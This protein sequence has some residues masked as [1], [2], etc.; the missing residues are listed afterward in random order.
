MTYDNEAEEERQ[1]KRL[2]MKKFEG[3]KEVDGVG[4]TLDDIDE[5]VYEMYKDDDKTYQEK[6]EFLQRRELAKQRLEQMNGEGQNV[7]A[8]PKNQYGDW[9]EDVNHEFGS[10]DQTYDIPDETRD[11][12]G[13]EKE[14]LSMHVQGD[15]S[16]SSSESGSKSNEGGTPDDDASFDDFLQEL[17]EEM[18]A[19]GESM[20]DINI[21]EARMVYDMFVKDANDNDG[22]NINETLESMEENGGLIEEDSLLHHGNGDSLTS[23]KIKSEVVEDKDSSTFDLVESDTQSLKYQFADEGN[24]NF[25]LDIFDASLPP[26]LPKSRVKRIR[27]AFSD[28]LAEPSLTTLIPIVRENL[29]EYLP[30]YWLKRKNVRDARFAIMKA[31]EEGMINVHVLNSMLEVETKAG[32]IDRALDF[33]NKQYQLSDLEPTQRSDRLVLEML[34]QKRR[35]SRALA[36]KEKIESDGRNLD[37]LSYGSLISHYANHKELGS[38]LM[39]LKECVNVHGYPPGEQ[40]L[41]N[42]RLMCRKLDVE[43]EVGL[44]KMI[45]PDP[46]FWLRDGEKNKKREMT[47]RG[48]RDVQGVR[49]AVVRI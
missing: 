13:R 45:G 36:F 26:E 23:E 49:N 29:P 25:E 46:L 20:D 6:L 28:V 33:H 38:A 3:L 47:K 37:L 43:E 27:R 1:G 40:S 48:R 41:K 22:T 15:E 2:K 44:E 16:Q 24:R 18:K 42:I 34:V 11:R 12:N 4:Y 30:L 35:M 10:S 14:H 8:P 17:E 31:E 32:S 19:N 9:T 21:D 5:D 7:E 39:V